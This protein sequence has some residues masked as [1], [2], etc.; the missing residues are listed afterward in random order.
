MLRLL[1]LIRYNADTFGGAHIANLLKYKLP[2]KNLLSQLKICNPL[3]PLTQVDIN[4]F[5]HV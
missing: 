3:I 2:M 5:M 4:I 1:I